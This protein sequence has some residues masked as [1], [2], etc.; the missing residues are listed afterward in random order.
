MGLFDLVEIDKD[1]V[2][3]AIRECAKLQRVGHG[4]GVQVI[5]LDSQL[6]DRSN[7]RRAQRNF[8]ATRPVNLCGRITG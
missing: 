7:R 5:K 2:L 6:V 8:I 4:I 3:A 1:Q